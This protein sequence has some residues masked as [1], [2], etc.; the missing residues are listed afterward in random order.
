MIH[1]GVVRTSARSSASW[2]PRARPSCPD[3]HRGGRRAAGPHLRARRTPSTDLT[4]AMQDTCR[5][6]EVLHPARR[7]R[8]TS[9]DRVVAARR[10]LPAR[11]RP[12]PAPRTSWARTSPASSTTPSVR[13]RWARTRSSPSP[14]RTTRSSDYTATRRGQALRHRVGRRRRREGRLPLL[15]EKEIATSP[16]PW[17]T[18]LGR[19]DENGRLTLDK[20]EIRRVPA[21]LDQQDRG[22]QRAARRPTPAR[23]RATPSTLVPDPH[24]GGAGPRVPLRDPIVNEKTLVVAV[25]SPGRPWTPSWPCDARRSGPR[26]WPCPTPTA[27]RDPA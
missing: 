13:W 25:S 8:R 1:N 5:R 12:G 11:D 2:P 4:V 24:R 26:S 17:R 7:P 23:W 20:I 19:L 22:D 21:A 27:P 18:L 10:K 15:M 6:L 9:P 16:P 3:G 14:P